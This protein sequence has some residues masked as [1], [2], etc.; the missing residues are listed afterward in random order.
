MGAHLQLQ[1]LLPADTP[2]DRLLKASEQFGVMVVDSTQFPGRKEIQGSNIPTRQ[3]YALAVH[4]E[5]VDPY[6]AILLN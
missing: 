2:T 1:L 6:H 4:D 5:T 3:A